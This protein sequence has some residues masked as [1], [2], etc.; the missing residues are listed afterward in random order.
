VLPAGVPSIPESN[1]GNY[2]VKTGPIV[3][4]ED[5]KDEIQFYQFAIQNLKIRNECLF[6]TKGEAAFECLISNH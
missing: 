2:H 3:I 5:D 6:F 1:S 4:V